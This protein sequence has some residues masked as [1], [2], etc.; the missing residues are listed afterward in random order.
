MNP[1]VA[2]T[3]TITGAP[4]AERPRVAIHANYLDVLERVG[5]APVLLTPAHSAASV[6]AILR[7]CAGLVLSGGEDVE[8]ARYGEAPHPQLGAVNP[9]RDAMEFAALAVALERDLPILAICRGC[10]VLNVFY[11]GTLYQDLAAQRPGSALHEQA[12]PWG[13]RPHRARVEPGSRLGEIVAGGEFCIN[14]FHHQ[15]VKDV[16]AGLEVTAVAEDGVIE[17]IEARDRGWVI[18]VQWH[19]ERCDA[20]VP[21]GDPDRRL[22]ASFR[23]A[24]LE[25][26]RRA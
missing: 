7:T 8:P 12:E 2:L 25:R 13:V 5:L 4:P 14:T 15:A 9:P 21:D 19:P 17:A 16:G 24:V 3:T 10:Q 20:A 1:L 18:G 6:E 23:Q 22:F 11:G 26:A